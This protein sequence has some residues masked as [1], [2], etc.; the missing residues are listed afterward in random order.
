MYKINHMYI[1][2]CKM[3][4][5]KVKY[6]TLRSSLEDIEAR[7]LKFCMGLDVTF[8]AKEIILEYPNIENQSVRYNWYIESKRKISVY[9]YLLSTLMFE[10]AI[11]DLI[12]LYRTLITFMIF[13]EDFWHFPAFLI[14]LD[15]NSFYVHIV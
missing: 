7:D 8:W 15:W 1:S 10:S 2:M 6:F 4:V 9:F 14:F 13:T 12:V 3:H 11:Q 5:C